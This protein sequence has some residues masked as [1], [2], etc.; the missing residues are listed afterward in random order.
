V[1]AAKKKIPYPS[2]AGGRIKE[3]V[4]RFFFESEVQ[5]SKEEGRRRRRRRWTG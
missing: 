3:R 2:T 1:S 5:A 4:A